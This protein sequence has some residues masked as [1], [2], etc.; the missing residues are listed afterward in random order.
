MK[1]VILA[2]GVGSRL[3]E[4]TLNKPKPLVEVGNYPIIWHIMKTY[5]Y[6]GINEFII[7]CGYK[8]YM[9]KEFFA[10]YLLHTRDVEIDIHQNK[11]STISKSSG[12]DNWKISLIDTGENTQTGGRLL[13]VKEFINDTFLMTY[14]DGVSNVDIKELIN[15]H[16]NK[17]TVGTM[18]VVNPPGRFG[19]P[20]IN[21]DKVVKFN[22]KKVTNDGWINGGF[23]VLEPE[24]F[25]FLRGDQEIFEDYPLNTI[26]EQGQLS[27]YHHKNFWHPMDTLRD[28]KFLDDLWYS[29]KA[30]WKIW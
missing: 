20:T 16:K 22:E 26:S 24:I 5:S 14:G 7:C 8:G 15:F 1:A 30:P 4:E 28:K 10:N 27:A 3:S 2:G 29:K 6:F 17:K 23:F 11:I 12:M 19:L 13:R 18:T 9:I 25:K 21:K